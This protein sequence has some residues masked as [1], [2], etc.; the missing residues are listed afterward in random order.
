MR[1]VAGIPLTCSV[2][3]SLLLGFA[4]MVN[5]KPVLQQIVL[6]EQLNQQ[7]GR[8]LLTYPFTAKRR[9][10]VPESVQ[11]IA[12]DERLLP[13]QLA[14]IEYWTDKKKYVKSARLYVLVDELKPMQPGPSP[15]PAIRRRLHVPLQ[16]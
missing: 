7:Y 9:R 2:S 12:P 8:E 13:A 15:L 14:E 4:T 3:L 1:T 11:V 10:C 16:I 5:G 6:R